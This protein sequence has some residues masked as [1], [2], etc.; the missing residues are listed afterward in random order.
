MFIVIFMFLANYETCGGGTGA[1]FR[2]AD[3]VLATF[4]PGD[5]V[6]RLAWRVAPDLHQRKWSVS[7]A[8]A[9]SDRH[10]RGVAQWR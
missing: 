1:A 9:P 7:A 4:E 10:R 2:Q 6:L 3:D 8:P 5:A